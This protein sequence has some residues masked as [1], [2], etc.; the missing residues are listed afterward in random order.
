VLKWLGI[1]A[2]AFAI[3]IIIATVM[4]SSY[5]I[6]GGIEDDLFF[7][8]TKQGFRATVFL[9]F[10]GVGLVGLFIAGSHARRTGPI[11]RATVLAVSMAIV[12]VLAFFIRSESTSVKFR[13]EAFSCLL[14]VGLFLL[15]WIV[16]GLMFAER[17]TADP[18]SD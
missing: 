7:P 1:A 11:T 16:L 17:T 3:A 2:G 10:V 5:P 18:G 15:A 9:V 8:F 12:L 4:K 6:E 13:T 14:G